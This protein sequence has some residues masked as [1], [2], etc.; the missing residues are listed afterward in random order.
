MAAPLVKR[1]VQYTVKIPNNNRFQVRIF[2][3]PE[4]VK[5]YFTF[6]VVIRPVNIHYLKTLPVKINKSCDYSIR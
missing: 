1:N 4:I 5:K 6:A 3:A 2:K